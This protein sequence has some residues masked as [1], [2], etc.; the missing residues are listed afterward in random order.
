[1]TRGPTYAAVS[2]GD[3]LPDLALP[4]LTRT[5]I[6][7]YAAGS[8]DHVPLHID[9]D[10][11]QAAGYPDVFMHGALGMA[12]IGRLLEQWVGPEAV[13][14]LDLR[15]RA[16]TYPGEQLTATGRVTEKLDQGQVKVAVKLANPEGQAK[17]SGHARIVL[18]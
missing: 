4:A 12:Y 7:L 3:T 2:V 10:F 6:A 13:H 17:L 9:S 1:V 8:G 5:T 18:P 16:I 14:E 15:F 11:A